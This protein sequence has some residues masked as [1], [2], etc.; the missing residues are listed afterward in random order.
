MWNVRLFI[1]EVNKQLAAYDQTGEFD[2][3]VPM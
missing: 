1:T 3:I 2:F